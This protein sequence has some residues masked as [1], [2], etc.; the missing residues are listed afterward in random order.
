MFV[1]DAHLHTCLSPCADLDMHPSALTEAAV[2]AGLDAVGVCDHNSAEN[3]GAVERAGRTAGLA[4]IPG[5]EITSAEE[6]H[7]LGLMPDMEAALELQSRVYRAL[8]GRND[9][10]AFGMQVVANEQAEVLGFNEHL[11]A[12]ATTLE[13]DRVVEAVH[14]I[15][16]LAV[17]SHVDR[18]GF[19]IIGQLGMIPA[20]LPLDALEI[21]RLTALPEA[22]A[23]FAPRDE[24]PL[25]CSSDAHEP[26]DVGKGA[27][28]AL[29][30]R[31]TIGEL[32]LAF[33]G[34]CGR[35][36]LG[37]G[38]PMEDLALHIL[39]IAQN[40]IEAGATKI[41][42]ELQE[43]PD[44]DRLVIEIR[45]NGTGMDQE[46]LSRV[47]DPFFTTRK[48]RRVGMGIPLLAEAARAAGGGLE[49]ESE[50]GKG[51]RIHATFRY[52]HIDRAPVGDIETTLM[53]LLA[54]RPELVIRFMHKVGEETFELDARE[55]RRAGINPATPEGLAAVR[56][57]IRR[58]EAEIR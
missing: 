35:Q 54:C 25:V 39:D 49:I 58:G 15:G 36:I 53:V 4:V 45:D 51:S 48:T 33:R 29:L 17:A 43:E 19:G 31:P 27:T 26:K 18:E 10:R 56:Q 3:A 28:W 41:E 14:S 30:E 9:E 7:I 46:T 13:V 11:L 23:R 47:R 2:R 52:H 32:N 22:R 24:F 40:S 12:G 1:I 34:Q 6:V 5:M 57:V 21:S 8:P 44:A 37:G 38:R 20:G 55:L 42:I 50:P 16:G